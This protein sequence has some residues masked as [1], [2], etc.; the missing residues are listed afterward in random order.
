MKACQLYV[1]DGRS[2]ASYSARDR[3]KFCTQLA[4]YTHDFCQEICYRQD[5][6]NYVPE[7]CE[8]PVVKLVNMVYPKKKGHPPT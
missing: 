7:D 1:L 2:R 8:E 5:L 6:L 4:T 3:Q